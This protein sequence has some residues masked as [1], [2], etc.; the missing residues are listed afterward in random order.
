[1]NNCQSWPR[2][3]GKKNEE[4]NEQVTVLRTRDKCHA[5]NG[6][7]SSKKDKC[8]ISE[9]WKKQKNN[10]DLCEKSFGEAETECVT[11]S[12]KKAKN[13]IQYVK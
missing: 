7:F 5:F 11:K 1:M 2:R 13:G 12:Q 8:K 10:V 3:E 6:G 4:D 9:V